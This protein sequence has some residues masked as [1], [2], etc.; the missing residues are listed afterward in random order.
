MGKP[1]VRAL[2]FFTS[3]RCEIASE[4]E[5]GLEILSKA[6]RVIREAGFDVF[7][8]RI[9]MATLDRETLLRLP[10]IMS[11]KEVLL[12]SGFTSLGRLDIGDLEYLTSNGIY[13]PILVPGG[14]SLDEAILLSRMIHRVSEVDPVNATRVAIGFHDDVFLTP[15]FP[16]SSSRGVRGVGLAFLYPDVIDASSL[17]KLAG[18]IKRAFNVFDEIAVMLEKSLGYTVLIDYSL[19][20][21]MERSVAGLI[22]SLGY[23]ALGPGF[24]Y[25]IYAINK[26]IWEYMNKGRATGFNEV[27][28]PY[29][30]DSKLIEYGGRN[31]ITARDFTR[32]ASTCVAGIDMLV[33]PSSVEK[34]ARLIMDAYSL[35]KI[36]SRPL[37][38]RVIPVNEEPGEKIRLGKFGEVFVIGY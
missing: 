12:S 17:D 30:E 21:W 27:M 35:S 25:A 4:Y 10:D 14:L 38:L 19:S 6:E 28:L 7:T 34:L 15:Y 5:Y 18:S 32:Y 29:A 11:D 36:K 33:L 26:I 3:G 20:P 16:D 8:K 24:N 2:T 13:V 22:E 9:S 37:A 23:S 1:V 31:L